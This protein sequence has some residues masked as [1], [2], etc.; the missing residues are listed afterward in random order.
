[1]IDWVNSKSTVDLNA[2]MNFIKTSLLLG[3]I[4]HGT[5]NGATKR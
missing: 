3:S 4:I 1:M 2:I 5:R